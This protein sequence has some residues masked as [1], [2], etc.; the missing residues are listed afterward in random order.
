[1]NFL[2][3]FKE[4]SN[5]DSIHRGFRGIFDNLSD[6]DSGI[7][8]S[9][10]IIRDSYDILID[11]RIDRKIDTRLFS[12][13]FNAV[14]SS[15]SG[16]DLVKRGKGIVGMLNDRAAKVGLS[17][18]EMVDDRNEYRI[19]RKSII[20]ISIALDEGVDHLKRAGIL[21]SIT[22]ENYVDKL[23]TN[24]FFTKAEEIKHKDSKKD[25]N[26][27]KLDFGVFL[28][29]PAEYEAIEKIKSIMKGTGRSLMDLCRERFGNVK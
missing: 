26:Q 13:A 25:N 6:P 10:R 16:S 14:S 20:P 18:D 28:Y 23:L 29:D 1:M 2:E 5:S 12:T 19:I 4:S 27:E 7:R 21:Y 24:V 15:K 8:N 11:L 17:V 3:Y 9:F 22:Y